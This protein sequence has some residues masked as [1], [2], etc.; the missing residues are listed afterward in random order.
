MSGRPAL[1]V[2]DYESD[3][4]GFD[5]SSITCVVS[6]HSPLINLISSATV[7]SYWHKCVHLVLVNLKNCELVNNAVL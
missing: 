5:P 2:L 1:F 6:G 7:V 3:D 4:R